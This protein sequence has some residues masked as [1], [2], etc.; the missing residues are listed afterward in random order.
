[1]QILPGKFNINCPRALCGLRTL[2]FYTEG[3]VVHFHAETGL[4]IYPR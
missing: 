3:N 2:L 4:D 1:M